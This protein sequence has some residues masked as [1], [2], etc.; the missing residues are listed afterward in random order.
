MPSVSIPA[1]SLLVAPLLALAPQAQPP[2]PVEA[3]PIP[4]LQRQLVL[5]RR[6]RR[7]EV[8]ENG[9]VPPTLQAM[10]SSM[11]TATSS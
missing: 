6:R 10:C 9:V 11:Q 5:D 8:V 4:E 7:L 1:L 2:P 3:Q